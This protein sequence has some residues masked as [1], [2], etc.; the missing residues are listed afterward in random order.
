MHHIVAFLQSNNLTLNMQKNFLAKCKFLFYTCEDSRNLI[1]S[2][3]LSRGH[4]IDIFVAWVEN[5]NIKNCN[6]RVLRGILEGLFMK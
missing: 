2:R 6:F 4:V 5:S 3:K 1:W